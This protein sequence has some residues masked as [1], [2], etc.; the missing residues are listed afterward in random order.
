MAADN[1]QV[2]LLKRAK[3]HLNAMTMAWYTVGVCYCVQ[4]AASD[5]INATVNDHRRLDIANAARLVKQL[6]R[7][8]LGCYI[9][10]QDWLETEHGIKWLDDL[11]KLHATRLAWIDDMIK[12]WE[13]KR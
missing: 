13:N 5:M 9:Y 8:R 7:R 10:L 6:I 2:Q 12:Y 4:R 1:V 3:V 11:P